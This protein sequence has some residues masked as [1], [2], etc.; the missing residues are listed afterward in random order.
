MIALVRNESEI[1]ADRRETRVRCRRSTFLR[2]RIGMIAATRND[3]GRRL[4]DCACPQ[5][6][7]SR[8]AGMSWGG[9]FGVVA[10][11]VVV[12]P[13]SWAL[14]ELAPRIVHHTPPGRGPCGRGRIDGPPHVRSG[15]PCR[16]RTMTAWIDRVED[17]TTIDHE[18]VPD[19]QSGVAHQPQLAAH[20]ESTQVQPI[21]KHGRT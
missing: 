13:R 8:R 1:A 12:A 21:R 4:D 3:P 9:A 10:P 7:R 6:L 5:R 11:L 18:L 14:P 19:D 17:P 15:E 20:H 2:S 16:D